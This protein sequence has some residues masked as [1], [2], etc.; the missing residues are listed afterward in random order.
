MYPTK[1]NLEEEELSHL[2]QGRSENVIIGGDISAHHDSN[3]N[4]RGRATTHLLEEDND[5]K[6]VTPTNLGTKRNPKKNEKK[7]I[8]SKAKKNQWINSLTTLV[9]E[10]MQIKPGPLPRPG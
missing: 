5:L 4:Q 9:Q 7:R 1:A 10:A 8:I 2:I 3:P 6:L